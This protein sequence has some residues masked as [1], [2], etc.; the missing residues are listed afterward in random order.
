MLG[1]AL[2]AAATSL[3]QGDG[4]ATTPIA[5]S[6]ASTRAAGAQPL[7]LAAATS[8]SLLDP[9]EWAE[10]ALAVCAAE[11]DARE[12]ALAA[13][14][15]RIGDE[16][17]SSEQASLPDRERAALAK[18][19]DTQRSVYFDRLHFLLLGD[20]AGMLDPSAD[21]LRRAAGVRP[22]AGSPLQRTLELLFA[23]ATPC[24]LAGFEATVLYAVLGVPFEES[25][26]VGGLDPSTVTDEIDRVLHEHALGL[27]GPEAAYIVMRP[28]DE[29]RA[30]AYV[31]RF[32]A[33]LAEDTSVEAVRS[34]DAGQSGADSTPVVQVVGPRRA[35]RLR[36]VNRLVGQLSLY[37]RYAAEPLRIRNFVHAKIDTLEDALGTAVPDS[38]ARKLE[39]RVER[40]LY[41]DA[42]DLRR[43][44]ATTPVDV[45]VE[46]APIFDDWFQDD[47]LGAVID[48]LY[49]DPLSAYWQYVQSGIVARRP[50]PFRDAATLVVDQTFALEDL[51]DLTL[52]DAIDLLYLWQIPLT[53]ADEFGRLE[54]AF[55]HVTVTRGDLLEMAA[56]LDEAPRAAVERFLSGLPD[57]ATISTADVFAR[58]LRNAN[59]IPG[60]FDLEASRATLALLHGQKASRVEQT[61]ADL[62]EE[63][64]PVALSSEGNGAGDTPSDGATLPRYR[65]TAYLRTAGRLLLEIE[66]RQLDEARFQESTGGGIFGWFLNTLLL[67]GGVPIE[68][69]VPDGV[70]G[71]E[72]AEVV[73]WLA[74]VNADSRYSYHGKP[75]SVHL[76]HDGALYREAVIEVIDTAERFINISAFDWKRDDGGKEIAYRLM[77]KKLGLDYDE[78][79]AALSGGLPPAPGDAPV[80]FLELSP[81]DIKRLMVYR[82]LTTSENPA[83]AE[84]RQ[85]LARALDGELTC[86]SLETCGDLASLATAAGGRYD[87]DRAEDPSYAHAWEAFQAVQGLFEDGPPTLDKTRP[88]RALGEYLSGDAMRHFVR[89]YG[90]RRADDPDS[91]L[92]VNLFADAKQNVLN[93]DLWNWN[94]RAP[95]IY[96]DPLRDLYLPLLEY[97]VRFL[98]WKGFLEFPW[99]VGPVPIPGRKIAGVIPMPFIP[100]PWL[101]LIPGFQWAGTGMSVFLQ[102]LLAADVRSWYAMVMHTKSVSNE[103][104]ALESGMGFGTKYFNEYENFKTWHDMGVTVRGPT[105]ADVN[106]HF[107]QLFNLARVNNTGIP[108]G[109]GVDIPELRYED[110]QSVDVVEDAVEAD[111]RSWVLST[112]PETRDFNYRGVFMAAL[113]AARKN[114]Y[115]ENAF[116]SDPLVARMLVR[117]AREFRSRVS[118]AGLDEHT[119]LQRRNDAVD[120][121]VILPDSS[122]KPIV[123]TVGTADFR[124]MLHLGIKIYRWNPPVGWSA[125]KMLHTKAWLIDYEEGEAAFTY[126]GSANATQRSHLL[127]NELG[128]ASTSSVFAREVYE[129]I[130]LRDMTKDSRLET[131]G[132]FHIVW[133]SNPVVRASYFLRRVLVSLFWFI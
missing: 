95:F 106:D 24:E 58:L 126:V 93:L 123:D 37:L 86:P 9:G 8:S 32:I 111:S 104:M 55:E 132:N 40:E 30:F 53:Y 84:A 47:A 34:A 6:A 26:I 29:A 60:D 51:E 7:P 27:N 10:R 79:T 102:Y 62:L 118:C 75:S 70:T 54:S 112:D 71:N 35:D 85:L 31:S 43:L 1:A 11:R 82:A 46:T 122:D 33:E 87:P 121:H 36:E 56:E 57:A 5:H 42:D 117:K 91:P 25:L 61:I 108:G 16:P 52:L 13:L 68:L 89:Q 20:R 77:T 73:N 21:E 50:Q 92:D 120:I 88:R 81:P 119:C 41:A 100:Y 76:V 107:V 83:L 59:R 90:A 109:K 18:S 72:F 69:W 116:F 44:V 114:V 19:M 94:A 105:V 125:S 101:N 131:R 2:P 49:D 48:H 97:D 96:T 98:L 12:A 127:D 74:P 115:I 133:S 110:Y 14:E 128:I 22:P 64:Y 99:H 66:A 67:G 15:A 124:E 23:N 39:S 63:S 17:R 78:L 129:Q 80:P 4:A 38:A 103:H 28:G 45:I 65:L 3:P 130:F 113:A